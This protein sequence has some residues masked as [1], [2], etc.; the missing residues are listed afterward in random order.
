MPLGT[1]ETYV[2]FS[3]FVLQISI[4]TLLAY[5]R[6]PLSSVCAGDSIKIP[7]KPSFELIHAENTH[8]LKDD[9]WPQIA[10][11]LLPFL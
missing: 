4:H 6:G 5:G 1:E 11:T 10:F 2:Y 8:P 9:A 7:S 3:V